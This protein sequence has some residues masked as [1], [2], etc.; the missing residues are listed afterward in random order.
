M[1]RWLGGRVDRWVDGFMV[2]R[3]GRWMDRQVKV[4]GRIENLP[5][6]SPLCTHSQDTESTHR[7]HSGDHYCPDFHSK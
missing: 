5:A 6:G 3:A 2:G 1:D 7:G 4:E